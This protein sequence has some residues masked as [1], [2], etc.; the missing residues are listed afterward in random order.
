MREELG[1]QGGQHKQINM[2]KRTGAS[3]LHTIN[4]APTGLIVKLGFTTEQ[5]ARMLR[6]RRVLPLS[7]D[8]KAPQLDARKLWEKVGK[9]HKQ[10]NKWADSYI[11][12]LLGRPEPFGEIT[13]KVTQSTGGRPRADYL[14]SRDVAAHLAMQANTAEGQDV[15]AYFLDMER[16]AL[17]LSEHMGIRVTAIVSTDNKVTHTLTR[18][19]A[20]A[21]KAGKCAQAPVK[22]VAMDRERL[23]KS[24]VCEVLT[25]HSTV[26]WRE[27]FGKGVRDVLNTADAL[28]YSNC[29]ETA[30]ALIEGGMGNRAKLVKVLS[31]AYGGKV[32]PAEYAAKAISGAV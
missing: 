8:T 15:R 19:A 3:L 29:Y 22:V 21:V 28:T 4:D 18:R 24:T 2:T 31:A 14:L 30:W 32:S 10:F 26:Y 11:K 27:T 25:G 16:L 1:Q 5:A 20:E 6:V 7:E 13:P 9:P 23:L 17:R 12:P